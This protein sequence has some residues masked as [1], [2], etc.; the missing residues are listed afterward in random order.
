MPFCISFFG[1]RS[2]DKYIL[3][4]VT[5]QLKINGERSEYYLFYTK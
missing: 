2:A 4:L 3:Q 5:F 1:F